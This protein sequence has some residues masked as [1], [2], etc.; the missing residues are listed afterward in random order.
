[1]RRRISISLVLGA[2]LPLALALTPGCGSTSSATPPAADASGDTLGADTLAADTLGDTGAN[3]TTPADAGDA[4]P[5]DALTDAADGGVLADESVLE[6]G[7]RATRDA[8]Y[9]QPTLTKAAAAKMSLDATFKATVTGN[10]YAQPLYVQDGPGGKGVFYVV[11][12]SNDVRALSEAD[13]TTIW[14]KSVGTAAGQTG[15]GCGNIAPL[16]ITGTPVIDHATRTLYLD[17]AVGT[18]TTISRHEIHALSIDDGTERAGFPFDT[19]GIAA[20]GSTFDP[21]LQNQRSALL[22]VG[23]TLYV[24]YGGHYGDCGNYHGWVLGIPTA[25]PSMTKGFATAARGGGMW[26]PGGPSSD[27]TDVFAATGNTFG[28]TTWS[29]GEAVLRFHAGPTFANATTD[30]FTPSNWKALDAGDVDLGGSGPVL[31]DLPG[32]TPSALV[33]A[34]GKNGVAYL[35]NRSNLGGFGTGNGTTGEGLASAKVANA[36]LINSATVYRTASGTFAAFHID[37]GTAA[38]C[39]AGQSGDLVGVKIGVGAPP[40]LSVA[41]CA[42]SAGQGS[43]IATTTSGVPASSDVVVWTDGAEGSKR[44]HGFDGETGAVV[45]AGGGAT[46]VMGNVRRF[47]VPIA[48]HGRLFVAGDG[49]LYAFVAK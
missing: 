11:T 6:R 3:D 27:G 39:P 1:M 14:S 22:L 23:G 41:W 34:G 31:F 44:L 4:G 30:W 47:T 18:A 10:V 40:T 35:L 8:V 26:S 42:A 13:G 32:A 16:G 15:A 43:P 28:A 36:E 19:A 12:E 24:T 49:A 25:A 38:G 33:L 21:K 5:A 17:A 45:F 46:D 37:S 9:L 2:A 48:V 29:Q 20:N 7:K